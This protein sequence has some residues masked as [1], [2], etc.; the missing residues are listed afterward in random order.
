MIHACCFKS[1]FVIHS[2]HKT[3][4]L[5][6]VYKALQGW[7]LATSLTASL[8][9]HSFI[10]LQPLLVPLVSQT[11]QLIPAWNAFL[12]KLLLVPSLTSFRF[13]LNSQLSE[14]FSD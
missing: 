10:L 13:L 9:T 1:L 5:T 4:A 2:L 6:L 12:L 7:P 3:E 11:A 8:S 14:A